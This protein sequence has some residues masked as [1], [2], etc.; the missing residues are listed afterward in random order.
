[1]NIFIRLF[2]K[3][4]NPAGQREICLAPLGH[5][6]A[7]GFSASGS[8]QELCAEVNKV[9][10]QM[11]RYRKL[12]QPEHMKPYLSDAV[13]QQYTV[14]V[15][16]DI[17]AGEIFRADEISVLACQTLGSCRMDGREHVFF[18]LHTKMTRWMER[19]GDG[20]FLCGDKTDRHE[21]YLVELASA[22]ERRGCDNV[23]CPSC[24][25]VMD[26]SMDPVC[27]FC[28]E[29]NAVLGWMIVG[30]KKA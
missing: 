6:S 15:Q 20:K 7:A 12:R 28:G 11:H 18:K 17:A 1:M 29:T 22:P 30:M 2:G 5:V 24:G 10:I 25:A 4:S 19:A 3:K 14:Q 13:W 16:Q 21:Y 26:A 27:P 9:F 8:R 23:N